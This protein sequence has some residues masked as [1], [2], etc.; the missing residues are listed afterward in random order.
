MKIILFICRK[1]S[2]QEAILPYLPEHYILLQKGPDQAGLQACSEM[3]AG[4]V[5]VDAADSAMATWLEQAAVLRRNQVFIGVA[6]RREQVPAAV[7]EMLEALLCGPFQERE[8]ARLLEKEWKQVQLTF[9][10]Q[11]LKNAANAE[12]TAP[13][14]LEWAREA[15]TSSKRDR[16]LCEFSRALGSSFNRDRL[17]ELFLETVPKLTPAGRLS[18]ILQT[19]QPGEYRVHAQKGLLQSSIAQLCFRREGGLL[20]W[21]AEQGRILSQ[22]EAADCARRGNSEVLQELQLLQAVLSVP[23]QAHGRLCG[24]LSL[25]PKVTGA[26]YTDEEMEI[27]FILAGNLA[28]ALRDIDLHNQLLYQ[29]TYIENILQRMNSGVIAINSEE[30]ITTCNRRAGELLGLEGAEDAALSGKDLRLL[31]SPLGDILYETM[32]TGREYQ[33]HHHQLTRCKTNL[34]ICTNQLLGEDQSVLGSVMIFEDVSERKQLEHEKRHADRLDVLNRFVGQLAH[35][36]KN[37]LVAIQT[38]TELLPEKYEEHSF[39][40][41]FNQTVRQEVRRLNELV[42]QLIAF[43]S[44]LSYRLAV[45]E[46]HEIIDMGLSMLRE[47]GKGEHTSVETSYYNGEALLHADRALLPRAFSYLLSGSFQ[48]LERG[49]QLF[50]ETKPEQTGFQE[51]SLRILFWDGQTRVQKEY[52]ETLF[53]PLAAR[54]S[55]LISLELPVSKKI[56]E[57]HGGHVA[58]STKS[59]GY[60]VIEVLLP[61]ISSKGSELVE[62][63]QNIDRR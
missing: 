61:T 25:G 44:T 20:G 45:S 21:L 7:Q 24:A 46:I 36:I 15:E 10:L 32:C 1:N 26:S 11:A 40:E 51:G 43:S 28:I 58:T 37:P 60:L 3:L 12:S 50:I 38:F 4:I 34:E 14:A 9:E 23:L 52:L 39:R 56:I 35:E 19:E 6:E 53:D 55:D 30:K 5:M 33:K 18:I 62:P 54:Q 16:L 59:G 49:G 17:L 22:E 29:K 48:V 8:T 63:S 47:Q 2:P 42:E 31:P 57:D 13:R 27:L 41:F